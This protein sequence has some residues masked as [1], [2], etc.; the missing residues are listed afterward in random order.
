MALGCAERG[1][2]ADGPFD[3]MMGKDYVAPHKGQYA[4]ALSKGRQVWVPLGISQISDTVV[5]HA[6]YTRPCVPSLA[7][8]NVFVNGTS[9]E[10]ME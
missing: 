4:D 2:E 8:R 10:Y 3:H 7:A 9:V 6:N 5:Q 1:V